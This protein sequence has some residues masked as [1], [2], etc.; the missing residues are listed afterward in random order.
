MITFLAPE[1]PAAS[2]ASGGSVIR[3]LE[4]LVQAAYSRLPEHR[5]ARER[6][7]ELNHRSMTIAEAC[8]AALPDGLQEFWEA[9]AGWFAM[10]SVGPLLANAQVAQQAADELIE[11]QAL[12]V[13]NLRSRGWWSGRDD[14]EASVGETLR[15][16]GWKVR[17]QPGAAWRA[18]RSGAVRALAAE[19]G[20]G[21]LRE[22]Q[23]AVAEAEMPGPPQP[24]DILFLAVGASSVDLIARLM[25]EA[26][27]RGLSS[28][29][30][31]FDYFGSAA[32]LRS[33]S[34][35]FYS[36]A[37]FLQSGE[38]RRAEPTP[39]A[40]IHEG[41]PQ[42]EGLSTGQQA[43]L[44]ARLDVV[45]A[46]DALPWMLR[47]T[48]S[49]RA[50]EA[51]QPKLVVGF[52]TYGPVM[53]PTIIAARRRSVPRICL[54]HGVI[55]PRY[56]ALPCLPYDEKLV[57]GRYAQGIMTA[58][59]PELPV[60]VTGHAM[61]D[62]GEEPVQPRQ[63]VLALR[64]GVRALVVLCTQF[65]EPEYYRPEGW[66]M[67]EVAETCRRLGVRLAVKLHPSDTPRNV[68]LYRQVLRD[69]DDLVQ[70]VRHGT[71]PLNE[72][73]TASDLMI[74]RDSTVVFEANLLDKPALTVNLSEW[75]EELPYAAT[76]GALGVS[77]FEA[78]APAIEAAL[79]DAQTRQRLAESRE[80]F[81]L[82]HTGPRDGRATE[83]IG[84]AME[85]WCGQTQG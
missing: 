26:S 23:R 58:A 80:E 68:R 30:L 85:R 22:L 55:G 29:I 12:V 51:F 78:I 54:Q 20:K 7:I 69:G 36:L 60:T 28:A 64:E 76:G 53:A 10:Y 5:L 82:E 46:R 66:W 43:A 34:L 50:L 62:V 14:L 15:Q 70:L 44:A 38:V 67:Q 48:A 83:R 19:Q 81:L 52:H 21:E 47:A 11:R 3:C 61:Y 25:P 37:A 6:V 40:E 73:L 18:L 56:L 71:L 1:L 9:Y 8:S 72:L 16:A 79:F 4:G 49:H 42:T 31:D 32:A 84:E 39:R 63:E 77:S 75:D 35:P 65:N 27:R 57:F 41:L 74:T 2:H 17:L 13:E 59:C 24:V 33:R 45:L